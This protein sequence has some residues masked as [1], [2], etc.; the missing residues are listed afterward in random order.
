M[1][2]KK[3]GIDKDFFIK[4]AQSLTIKQLLQIPT[5]FRTH[6]HAKIIIHHV[7]ARFSKGFPVLSHNR[8]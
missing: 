4:G 3:P 5:E 7:K 1:S 6:Q 2:Q 8:M